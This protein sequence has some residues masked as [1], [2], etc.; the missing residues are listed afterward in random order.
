MEILMFVM[1][2]LIVTVIAIPALAIVGTAL[3]DHWFIKTDEARADGFKKLA[4]AAKIAQSL[5]EKN[6]SGDSK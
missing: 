6:G 3:I 5:L 1:Y 2:V 4:E